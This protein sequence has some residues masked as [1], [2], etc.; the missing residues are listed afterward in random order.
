MSVSHLKK[1]KLFRKFL[2]PFANGCCS[3]KSV[4][5]ICSCGFQKQDLSWCECFI[6]GKGWVRQNSDGKL[7][8]WDVL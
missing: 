2:D 5:R 6:C 7:F 3:I 4:R 1:G 8:T